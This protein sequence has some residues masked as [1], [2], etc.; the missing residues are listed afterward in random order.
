ML[1]ASEQYLQEDDEWEDRELSSAELELYG[2][3]AGGCLPPEYYSSCGENNF[4]PVI[5]D[6]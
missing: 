1:D 2:I 5:I 6:E 3:P 4:V